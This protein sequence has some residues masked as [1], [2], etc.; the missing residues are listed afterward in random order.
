MAEV[1]VRSNAT[2]ASFYIACCIF[3][4]CFFGGAET[5]FVVGFFLLC[6]II[7]RKHNKIR[8]QQNLDCI[9]LFL[10]AV[11]C[12]SIPLDFESLGVVT[13]ERVS[14]YVRRSALISLL[15]S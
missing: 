11:L 8:I 4:M 14:H 7:K 13:M 6:G 9:Y 5:F 10:L 1:E 2:E 12:S 3:K 15:I